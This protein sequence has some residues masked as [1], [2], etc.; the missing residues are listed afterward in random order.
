MERYTSIKKSSKF[1][2]GL[3]IE[4]QKAFFHNCEVLIPVNNNQ[5]LNITLRK[6]VNYQEKKITIDISRHSNDFIFNI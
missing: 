5:K 3:K 1:V 2:Q 6:P 4:N